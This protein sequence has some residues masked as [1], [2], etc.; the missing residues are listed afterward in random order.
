MTALTPALVISSGR[1]GLAVTRGLGEMGVPVVVLAWDQQDLA[2]VSRYAAQT[3]QVPQAD[4]GDGAFLASLLALAD[5]YAGAVVV[6]TSDEAV[7]DVARNKATLSAAFRVDCPDW[8]VAERYIDKRGTYEVAAAIGVPLPR[9]V[10]PSDRDELAAIGAD[11]GYPCLIKPRQSHLYTPHFHRKVSLVH[12]E[13]ELH[14]AYDAA[15]AVGVEVMVQELIPGP[16]ELGVNY[17]AY[18]SGGRVVAECTARKLRLAPPR[19]GIPRVVLSAPVPEVVE[20]GRAILDA[21]GVDGFS[22]T[23]FKYDTRSRTYKLLEVNGRHNYSSLL[24][25]RC[26]LNF[27]WISYREQVSG[28]LP[29]PTR[30][31][32]GL[33]WIDELAD[34]AHSATAAGRDGRTVRELARPW[35]GRHVFAVFDPRDPRPFL[36]L[37]AGAPRRARS[38]LGAAQVQA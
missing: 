17:N 21:L 27:P 16:D 36:R 2:S 13:E 29:G 12:T 11:I 37:A 1:Q 15:T 35:L 23:E 8:A 18:R 28:E 19:F 25:I 26:G 32:H 30:V 34:L 9:T 33:Y 10:T 7:A 38:A 31:R 4:Q 5:R 24:S 3:V 20:P 6:P 22:C 14:A